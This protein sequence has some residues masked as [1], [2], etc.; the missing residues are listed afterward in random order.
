MPL[1]SQVRPLRGQVIF[2]WATPASPRS[3]GNCFLRW[4]GCISRPATY[5]RCC[6]ATIPFHRF[7]RTAR[8]ACGPH[9]WLGATAEASQNSLFLRSSHTAIVSF[10]HS[11]PPVRRH[12]PAAAEDSGTPFHPQ[13]SHT[14]RQQNSH[15]DHSWHPDCP[16]LYKKSPGSNFPG[17]P[18]SLFGHI[19]P[20][21]QKTVFRPVIFVPKNGKMSCYLGEQM[22]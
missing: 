7:H 18:V 1:Y 19:G 17:H 16:K 5:G 11:F 15:F 9:F 10:H 14:L 20:R 12:P 3:R 13:A 4:C 21:P 6:T 8:P 2:A 22:V